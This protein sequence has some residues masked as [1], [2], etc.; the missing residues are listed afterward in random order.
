MITLTVI[1]AFN[2]MIL[3]VNWIIWR[4]NRKIGFPK[5]EYY[6]S[7]LR[8]FNIRGEVT[9]EYDKPLKK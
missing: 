5:W 6:K 1:T 7:G 4:R 8:F 2:L 3:V 9:I